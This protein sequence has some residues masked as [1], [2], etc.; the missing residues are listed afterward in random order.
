[1]PLVGL[2]DAHMRGMMSR[3]HDKRKEH[4]M[5]RQARKPKPKD[6]PEPPVRFDDWG[7]I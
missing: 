4:A 3:H 7:A 5:T 6:K 2:G 1:M